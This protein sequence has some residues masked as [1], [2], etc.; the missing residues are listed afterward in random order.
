ME[1]ARS[2][3]KLGFMR[4]Y[5]RQL[6]ESHVWLVTVLFC[7]IGIAATVEAI[8]F[9]DIAGTLV[10]LA[11]VFVAGLVCWHGFQ[12]YRKLMLHA[13]N[14]ASQAI[15]EKCDAYGRLKVLDENARMRVRCRMC[16]NEWTIG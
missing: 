15:C 11:F 3:A 6:I 4:W 8:N 7:G 16:G 2:I 9:K 14:I 5:E 13:E 12:R 10:T 1:P